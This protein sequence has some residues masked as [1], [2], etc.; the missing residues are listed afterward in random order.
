M[1]PEASTATTPESEKA[2]EYIPRYINLPVAVF[3][4]FAYIGAMCFIFGI[5]VMTQGYFQLG[6]AIAPASFA[7]LLFSSFQLGFHISY[8][9]KKHY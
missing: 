9:V 3:M 1:T 5:Y 8:L 2:E 4:L 7:F 6:F